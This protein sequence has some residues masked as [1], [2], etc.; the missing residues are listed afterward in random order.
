MGLI[1]PVTG[2]GGVAKGQGIENDGLVPLTSAKWGTWKGSPSYGIL[3][4]GLDHLE[5]SNTLSLGETWFDVRAF[6]LD[7][8]VNAKSNQ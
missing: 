5:V 3:T 7:M 1:V 2:I 4:T 8:A 6:W